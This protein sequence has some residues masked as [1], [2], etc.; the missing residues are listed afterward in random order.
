MLAPPVALAW[1][2]AYTIRMSQQALLDRALG[3]GDERVRELTKVWAIGL[4]ERMHIEVRATGVEHIDWSG[5]C[6][7]MANHQS[8]LDVLALY[9]ALPR[10]FGFIAKKGLYSVPFFA[11]VMRAVGCIPIDRSSRV[12]ALTSMRAAARILKDGAPIAIFPEG[13]RS[14]GDRI[15]P[16]KKGAFHLVQLAQVP[17]YPIGIRGAAALMPRQNTG[18][19]PGVIEVHVGPAIPPPPKEDH[20]ARAEMMARVRAELSRLAALPEI[21]GR[22]SAD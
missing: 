9:R 19:R 4:C 11:G 22:R 12:D 17:C 10:C 6:V 20:H 18:I 13:T 14:L 2:F 16:L 21:D 15:A 1:A 8:Y 7:L 5:P 3:A